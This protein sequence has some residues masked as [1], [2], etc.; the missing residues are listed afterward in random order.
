MPT[1]WIFCAVWLIFGFYFGVILIQRGDWRLICAENYWKGVFEEIGEQYSAWVVS[2]PGLNDQA[3]KEKLQELQKIEMSNK[4]HVDDC[5]R[6][7]KRISISAVILLT[8]L[9]FLDIF[10]I[11]FA[12]LQIKKPAH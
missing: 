11:L 3:R 1:F 9:G 10:I 8:V 4:A 2:H 6:Y 5:L 7:I 12:F